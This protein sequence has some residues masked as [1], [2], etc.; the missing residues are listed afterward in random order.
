MFLHMSVILFTGGQR[1]YPSMHCRWY[2]SIP[3]SRSQG[4]WYPSMACRFPGPHSGGKLRGLASGVSRPTPKGKL[5]GLAGWGLQ[6]HTWGG[7]PGPHLGVSRP[8]TRG[9]IPVCTEAD[10]PLPM[11]TTVGSMYPTGMHSCFWLI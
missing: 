8:T 10:C 1:W 7:S 9:C 4:G 5:R 2:P 11:A 6:V 3:C